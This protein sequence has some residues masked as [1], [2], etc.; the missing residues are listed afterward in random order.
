MHSP[1]ILIAG[2]GT[3]GHIFPA[4]AVARELKDRYALRF[5]L[6]ERRVALSRGWCRRCGFP[7]ELIP[8]GR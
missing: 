3:G 4:L 6:S 5:S 1:R 7:L 2:G 8:V